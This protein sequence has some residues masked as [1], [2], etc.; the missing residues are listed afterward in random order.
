MPEIEEQTKQ[1]MRH[2]LKSTADYYNIFNRAV[3]NDNKCVYVMS[4][5]SELE[6]CAIGR[7]LS[8]YYKRWVRKDKTINAQGEITELFSTFGVPAYFKGM[9]KITLY[10]IQSLHDKEENWNISGLSSKG[11]AQYTYIKE[12]IKEFK[13]GDE[14]W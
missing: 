9:P 14:V 10:E 3:N 13:E 1:R 7:K 5:E 8:L 6:G 11:V 12:L 4:E 2:Y